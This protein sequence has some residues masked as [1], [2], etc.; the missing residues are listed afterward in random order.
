M[1]IEEKKFLDRQ[2]SPMYFGTLM[3]SDSTGPRRFGR[4]WP[5]GPDVGRLH[6]FTN[7][8]VPR[9][10][11]TGC[12]QQHLLVFRA[13]TKANRWSSDTG[14]QQLFAHLDGEALHVAL[15]MPDRIREHWK[16]L[17]D[18]LL[19][20]YITPRRLAVFRQQFENVHRRPGLDPATFATEFGIL[21]LRGFSNMKEK[22]RDLMVRNKF[23][24]SQQS[25]DLRR[26]LDSAAPETLIWDIVDSCRIWES[27]AETGSHRQ[28][29]SGPSVQS[30]DVTHPP[31]LRRQASQAGCSTG[32]ET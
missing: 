20:Y 11:G 30:A 24:A 29:V 13:I 23:I 7:T 10:D 25:C 17:V 31:P 2:C 4:P 1:K 22:A 3:K 21:A 18:E 12:W 27:H 19:A 6:R 26:H 32:S 9:F 15:L 28:M 14:A 8:A 16:D 5:D